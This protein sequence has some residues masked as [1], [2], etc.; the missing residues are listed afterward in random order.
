MVG[1]NNKTT[2]VHYCQFYAFLKRDADNTVR[3]T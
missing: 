3:K 2:Q 1:L